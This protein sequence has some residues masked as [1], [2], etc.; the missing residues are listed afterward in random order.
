MTMDDDAFWDEFERRVHALRADQLL[1]LWRAVLLLWVRTYER[2][3]G[4]VRTE[5]RG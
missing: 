1:L 3:A 4:I 5:R 2:D